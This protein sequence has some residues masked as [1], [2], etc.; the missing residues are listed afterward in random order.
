MLRLA[1]TGGL[2]SGKSAVA[3]MLRQLGCP[4]VDADALARRELE[5]A[6]GELAAAFGEGVLAPGGGVDRA[7]VAELVFTGPGAEARRQTLHRILHP[8]VMAAAGAQLA[9]WEAEGAACAGV[10]AALLIEEQRLDG[11][12]RVLL[13]TAPVETRI[14]RYLA[15]GG[16][17]AQAEARIAVQ[18]SDERKQARA[19]AVIRNDGR[20]EDTRRQVAAVMAQWKHEVN[21]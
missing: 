14:E 17:R 5:A 20:L 3:E 6:A 12:D 9:A 11:F 7:R 15:R 13:V 1:I 8:R 18:W 21:P 19:D 4:V 10:E 16:S 2:C